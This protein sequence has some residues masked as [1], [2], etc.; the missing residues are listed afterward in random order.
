MQ[1]LNIRSAN[2]HT[3]VF[4]GKEDKMNQV[5]DGVEV[6]GSDEANTDDGVIVQGMQ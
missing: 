5:F 6:P 3:S 1:K 4:S 2:N